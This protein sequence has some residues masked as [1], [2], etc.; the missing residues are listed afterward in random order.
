MDKINYILIS[1]IL[2]C[3]S[4][5]FVNETQ[6]NWWIPKEYFE[7]MKNMDKPIFEYP[8][9]TPGPADLYNNQPY[10]LLNDQFSTL[11]ES[12]SNVN[13]RSCYKS[14][15]ERM[16][17]KTGTYRQMTNNYKRGYPDSCTAPFQEL[18]SNFYKGDSMPIP[19]NNTG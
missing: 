8:P 18:V 9:D 10:Y 3:V 11:G 5:A 4:A 12:L 2:I 13:S 16:V 17:S 7:N 15:F 6:K 1:F 19:V 14:D